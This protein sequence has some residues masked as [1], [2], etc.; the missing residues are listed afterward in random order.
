MA[1]TLKLSERLQDA[2][3]GRLRRFAPADERVAADVERIAAQCVHCGLC[4][5]ACPTYI[6]A[7]DERD[8]PRGRI[9]MIASMFARGGPPIDTVRHHVGRCLSCMSCVTA[10]PAGVDYRHLIGYAKT[11]IRATTSPTAREYL[12]NWIATNVIPHPRRL[13]WLMRLGPMVSRLGGV[14][15]WLRLGEI[16][17]LAESTPSLGAGRGAF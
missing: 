3:A 9:T 7:G 17:A 2:A 12:V 5:A 15:R 13:V 1:E 4:N 16:A 6:L 14:L 8:G 11:H 10:C